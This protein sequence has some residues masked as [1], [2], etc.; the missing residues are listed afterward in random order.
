MISFEQLYQPNKYKVIL[1]EGKTIGFC[2]LWNEPEK[3]IKECPILLKKSAIFHRLKIVH[4][5]LLLQIKISV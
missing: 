4:Y 5:Y 2:T 3:A 1:G